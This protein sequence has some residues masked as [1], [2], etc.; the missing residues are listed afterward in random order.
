MSH[1]GGAWETVAVEID[2]GVAWVSLDRPEKRNAMNPKLNAEMIDVLETL[3]RDDRCGVLVL[4]GSGDSY[5]AVMDLNE[6]FREVDDG[7]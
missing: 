3:E 4:T 1:D 5:S 6:Y 7:T 2:D